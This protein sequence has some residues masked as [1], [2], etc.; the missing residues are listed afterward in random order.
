M[1]QHTAR[2]DFEPHVSI[3]MALIIRL[4]QFLFYPTKL[5][6]DE[7]RFPMIH[8][9]REIALVLDFAR[10]AERG[11]SKYIELLD[12][13]DRVGTYWAQ[14]ISYGASL[15]H[16][17]DLDKP[18]HHQGAGFLSEAVSFGLFS[19]VSTKLEADSAILLQ[20]KANSV[21]IVH[22]LIPTELFLHESSFSG[23]SFS[24]PEMIELLVKY[25]ANPNRV[26]KGHTPWQRFLTWA[27]RTCGQDIFDLEYSAYLY[28]GGR[29]SGVDRDFSAAQYL[30]LWSSLFRTML[31]NGASTNTTCTSNHELYNGPFTTHHRVLD[32]IDDIF[33]RFLPEDALSLKQLVKVSLEDFETQGSNSGSHSIGVLRKRR[34]ES[35]ELEPKKK[36]K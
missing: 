18:D 25:G 8:L 11:K 36:L 13:S 17:S 34:L 21:L 30:H 27:H 19:Y 7:T 2:T 1:I 4:K 31:L 26:S 6:K 22:A 9:A 29:P 15:L 3:M 28:S 32:V 20:S 10:A 33:G 24:P 35:H 12:E 14:Q 5:A 16:W 23:R